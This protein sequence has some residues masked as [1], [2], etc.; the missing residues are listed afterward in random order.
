MNDPVGLSSALLFGFLLGLRHAADADHLAAVATLAARA[1]N[2]RH[3][4][5][6]GVAWGLG[7]TLTLLLVGGAVLALGSSIPERLAEALEFIVGIMLVTLGLDVLRRLAR[8]HI[9]VHAHA[10]AGG[11]RYLHA[12]SHAGGDDHGHGHPPPLR[13]LAVG[14]MHGTAGSAALVVLS[15]G[16]VQSWVAGLLYIALFGAGSI[17]GMALLSAVIALPLRWSAGVVWLNSG[18]TAAV[19]LF[20]CGL[21]LLLVWEIGFDGKLLAG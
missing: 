14:M 16:A 17:F 20:S 3:S 12:H 2:L 21:G 13:A 18:L 11:M 8:S 5:R 15:L 9:H 7:H 19:G 10:R 6:Q 4:V 1:G